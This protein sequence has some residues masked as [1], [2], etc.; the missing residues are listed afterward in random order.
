[1]TFSQVIKST[2]NIIVI[3]GIFAGL[4]GCAELQLYG[5]TAASAFDSLSGVLNGDS[6]KPHKGYITVEDADITGFRDL[7]WGDAPTTNMQLVKYGKNS[8]KAVKIYTR[9]NDKLAIGNARLQHIYYHFFQ[10]KLFKVSTLTGSRD[11]SLTL[12]KAINANYGDWVRPD[13]P[14]AN[15]LTASYDIQKNSG[16]LRNSFP[17]GTYH[18]RAESGYVN[19]ICIRAEDTPMQ[20]GVCENRWAS[21]KMLVSLNEHLDKQ[22]KAAGEDM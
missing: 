22:A 20:D 4:T 12:R 1:M 8:D 9:Q 6:D 19:M 2:R 5:P 17:N 16:D 7:D 10:D 3:S 11:D 13:Y 21:W 14:S 18:W 15:P